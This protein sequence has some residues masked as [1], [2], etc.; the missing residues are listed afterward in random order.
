MKKR[1]RI[2]YYDTPSFFNG[3]DSNILSYFSGHFDFSS[4]QKKSAKL[5]DCNLF[6]SSRAVP[7]TV[8]VCS[9]SNLPSSSQK[10]Y[11]Q[12]SCPVVIGKGFP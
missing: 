7:S 12:S 6:K 5:S 8:S 3:N 11:R 4:R 1:R 10:Q 2:V 9:I